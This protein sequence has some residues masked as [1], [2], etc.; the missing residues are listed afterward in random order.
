MLRY[1]TFLIA[2][3]WVPE[4]GSAEDAKQ[5]KY[6]VLHAYSPYQHVKPGT[7]YPAIM[8]MTADSDTS[9]VDPMHA[10]KM[11]PL[12]QA[13]AANGKSKECPICGP[14]TCTKPGTARLC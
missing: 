2:K 11:P 8:F 9:R 13:Q 4:D 7:E 3:F 10:K 5:F 14:L 6:L 1:Q 12:M